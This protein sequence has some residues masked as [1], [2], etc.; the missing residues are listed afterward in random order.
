MD[1]AKRWH[2]KMAR[3]RVTR[4]ITIQVWPDF[5]E[6]GRFDADPD[7]TLHGLIN[8]NFL[9]SQLRWIKLYGG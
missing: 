9:A 2:V 1:P 5:G 7:H 4:P 8:P 6:L 3:P